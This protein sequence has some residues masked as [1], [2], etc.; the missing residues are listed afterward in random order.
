MKNQ[1]YPLKFDPI[2]QYRLWGGRKLEHLLSKPLPKDEA[3]GEAWILSDR[4]DHASEV[5][6]G[7]FKGYT[8]T[9]LMKDNSEELMGKLAHQFERFPLLLKFL[10][11]KEVLSVQVH[12]S[13]HQKAYIPKGDT[14]KT[15]AWVVLETDKDSRIY[16]GLK[17]E[18]NRKNLLEALENHQL[19]D[20]LH[21]FTPE[22]G[23]AIFI[24]S[25]TVHTLGGTV[26]FEV[27]ENSD[28]TFRLSD[29][30]RTDPKTGEPRKLQ[31]EEALDCIDFNQVNIGPVK[32]MVDAQHPN[33]EKLFDN[34]HFVVNR[35]KDQSV[36]KVGYTNEPTILVCLAGAGTLVYDAV[37]YPINRGEVMLLP[38]IIGAGKLQPSH[39]M[40]LL[41]IS[42]PPKKLSNS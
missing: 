8:L 32:P 3:I 17:P 41:Q 29:W 34:E 10:D 27:Q 4:E 15:E 31:V 9:Q 6:E 7:A 21:G 40:I 19:A 23:D 20:R 38:A 37:D 18:T 2:Y 39:E 35:I 16:A 25:G 13:D 1:W 33:T 26:V 24:H 12:P 30:D 42:I 5:L 28:V 11:C 22:I 14:G 36:F